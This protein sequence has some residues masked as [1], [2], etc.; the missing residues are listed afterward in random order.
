MDGSK[1]DNFKQT[2]QIIYSTGED[3][4]P[5]ALYDKFMSKRPL[6]TLTAD[7][8][9]YLTPIPVKRIVNKNC[10]YYKIPMGHNTLGNLVKNACAR[11]GVEG[12]KTNHSLRKST[13]TDL[14]TAGLP[15]H[16][17]IRITGHEHENVSSIQDL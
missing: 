4:D 17:I 15:P 9:L 5:V 11:A 1:K 8:P 3:D 6:E 10:W 13:A 16:K 14:T 12:R 2:K 7:S